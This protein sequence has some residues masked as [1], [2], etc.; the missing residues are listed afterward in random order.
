MPIDLQRLQAAICG[1]THGV[2]PAAD[3]HFELFELAPEPQLMYLEDAM[4]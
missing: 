1:S 3:D 2:F 4:G